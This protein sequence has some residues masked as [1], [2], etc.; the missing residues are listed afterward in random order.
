MKRIN[1]WIIFPRRSRKK[2]NYLTFS[3]SVLLHRSIGTRYARMKYNESKWMISQGKHSSCKTYTR[4]WRGRNV[5][6]SPSALRTQRSGNYFWRWARHS[7]SSKAIGQEMERDDHHESIGRILSRYM[8][9][10]VDIWPLTGSL[11]TSWAIK[12]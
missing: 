7:R 6:V 4:R 11:N 3:S 1:I 8:F 12:T 10:F 2:N 9:R 5:L